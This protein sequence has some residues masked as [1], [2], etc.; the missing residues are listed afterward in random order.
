MKKSF[1]TIAL[2]IIV[3]VLIIIWL[4][5]QKSSTQNPDVFQIPILILI[6]GIGIYFGISR[7]KSERKGQPAEDE[8]S[9]KLLTKASSVSFYLSLYYL[10]I[11]GYLSNKINLEN[12]TLLGIGIIGMAFLLVVS[13]IF[14]KIKGLKDDE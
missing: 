11:L 8:L 14:Y 3:I 5:V 1:L 7:I 13:W 2:T 4:F 6:I 12:H 10:L 9:K